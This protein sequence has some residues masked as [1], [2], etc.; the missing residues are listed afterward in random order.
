MVFMDSVF[1]SFS[2]VVY[3]FF[4]ARAFSRSIVLLHRLIQFAVVGNKGSADGELNSPYD[5]ACTTDGLLYAADTGNHRLQVLRADS[6]G[7][8]HKVGT[9][10]SGQGQ[11]SSPYGVC[12]ND[13]KGLVYVTDTYIR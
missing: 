3:L 1:C 10:G 4:L 8:I 12:L 6:G 7:F 9:E 11:F 13:D 5:V 2:Y